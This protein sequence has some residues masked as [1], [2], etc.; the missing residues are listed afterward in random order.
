MIRPRPNPNQNSQK[1][2]VLP[3]AIFPI[4]DHKNPIKLGPKILKVFG[5]WKKSGVL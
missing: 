1:I 4:K 5:E 3:W 2:T